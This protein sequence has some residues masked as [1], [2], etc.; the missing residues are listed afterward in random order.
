LIT[1]IRIRNFKSLSDFALNDVGIFS[2][3]IGLNGAGKTTLLQALD[4]LSHLVIGDASTWLEQRGWA[5][6]D[7]I[8]QG[9][10]KRTITFLI[11]MVTDYGPVTW[12]GIYNVDTTTCSIEN[13]IQLTEPSS[14][15]ILRK[16]RNELTALS[17]D[18]TLNQFE[19]QNISSLKYQGSILSAFEYKNPLIQQVIA[20]L[21]SL[22]SL[23]LLAPHLLRNNSKPADDIGIGGENL[24]GYISKLNS[25]KDFPAFLQT[26]KEFYP[27]LENVSV[28]KKQYGWKSLLFNEQTGLSKASFKALHINDGMLRIMAILSQKYSS[29]DFLFF[30]EIE[31]GINQELVEKLIDILQDFN[32]KQVMVTTHSSLVLNYLDDDVARKSVILLYKDSNGHTHATR[33]FEI[34]EIQKKLKMLGPGE[35]MSDTDLTE[36]VKRLNQ[37]EPGV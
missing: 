28:K 8:T 26:L 36:L 12:R 10:K 33:F 21:K 1:S 7:L 25:K 24:A 11:D 22:K 4:F 29:H 19:K 23:E 31:N 2:C 13:I 17:D 15:S 18:V 34:P 14:E 37:A 16:E 30:D 27:Q 35:A 9:N 3:L 6:S 5:N 20:T 32:S